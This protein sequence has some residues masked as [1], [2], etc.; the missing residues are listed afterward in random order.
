MRTIKGTN[1]EAE[2]GPP[3]DTES[4]GAL[5]LG[6]IDSRI[7]SYKFLLFIITQ[8]KLFYY[9]RLDR[10]FLFFF[11]TKQFQVLYFLPIKYHKSCRL[12]PYSLGVD[13]H[14]SKDYNRNKGVKNSKQM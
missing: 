13:H 10:C 14:S 2:N 8:S 7:V 4:T 3:P 5:N 6:F 1:Y 12:G 9:S 11:S